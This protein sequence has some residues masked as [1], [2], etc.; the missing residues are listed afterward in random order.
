MV[1]RGISA[2]G[3]VLMHGPTFMGNPLATAVASASIDLLQESDWQGRV[4]ALEAQL[5]DELAPLRD[6]PQVRDVRVLGAIG[7]VQTQ[8]PVPVAEL[9]RHFVEQ[10][11][12]IRPFNDLIYLMPPYVTPREDLSRLTGAIASSLDVLE[13]QADP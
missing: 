11:V 1:A 10:G 9:Q 2:G 8:K 13:A 5:R 4:K 12:W 6:H 3:G 7:V